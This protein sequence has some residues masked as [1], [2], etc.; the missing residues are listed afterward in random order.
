MEQK[1]NL[2]FR[3]YSKVLNVIFTNNEEKKISVRFLKALPIGTRL[4]IEVHN[5]D[6]FIKI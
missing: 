2:Q 6:T 5:F 1:E 3:Y 4:A